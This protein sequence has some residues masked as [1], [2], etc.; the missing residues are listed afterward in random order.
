MISHQ[1]EEHLTEKKDILGISI[2]L[3]IRSQI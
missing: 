3:I 1:Q 2:M